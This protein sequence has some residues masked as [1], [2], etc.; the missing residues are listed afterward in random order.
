MTQRNTMANESRYNNS[1]AET[2]WMTK[3]PATLP[4]RLPS[5]MAAIPNP[6]IFTG[7]VPD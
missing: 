1:I 6:K 3:A 4:M 7:F 5:E 2:I